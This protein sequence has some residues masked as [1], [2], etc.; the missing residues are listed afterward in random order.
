MKTI[1]VAGKN[2]IA[3]N[4]LRYLIKYYPENKYLIIPNKTDSG[5][6]TWQ[7][8]L[9]FEG[10][11]LKVNESTLSGLYEI[12]DLI[13]LSLEF[14]EI[15]KPQSFQSTSLF[16]IHF[17]ALPKYKGM[18]TSIHPILNGE[19]YSG[20][21]L[22]KIDK[23]IDTGD[24]IDQLTFP[25]DYL[26]TGRELYQK[27]LDNA[28]VLFKKNLNSILTGEFELIRQSE[29]DSSYYSKKSIDFTDIKIDFYK[30][31]FE[32][33]NQIRAFIFRDYQLP[34]FN[35][36][37]IY[38]SEITNIKSVGRPG[39][40]NLEDE[41]AI[42]VASVDYDVKL[43]KDYYLNLWESCEYGNVDKVQSILKYIPDVNLRNSKGW[44]ALIIATYNNHPLI[45]EL[46]L[47]HKVKADI[48]SC[49]YKGTT[50]L[51]YALSCFKNTGDIAMIKL[52]QSYNPD[53]GRKD[54]IGKTIFD[55]INEYDKSIGM[56]LI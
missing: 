34:K 12:K 56:L 21:T 23:G 55:Y 22:H 17:S 39:S 4:A 37:Y 16:N 28:F 26:T 54:E 30:T 51:M 9:R 18:F 42:S 19:K 8:S 2:E 25:I 29:F 32:I 11:Q 35:Q 53:L 10:L 48:N 1:C 44:N 52:I 50:T 7:P 41:E 45:V 38:K 49:N 43:Y 20:V 6:S 31:A 15:I 27:Y 24:V 40:V 14:D 36:F 5:F 47:D 46:L 3:V 33:H 13:F